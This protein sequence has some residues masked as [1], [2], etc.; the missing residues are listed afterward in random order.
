MKVCKVV[1]NFLMFQYTR[2]YQQVEL[3]WTLPPHI[4]AVADA[5]YQALCNYHDDQCCII[6]GESGAGKTE[7]AKL[8]VH[9]VINL[10]RC[11]NDLQQ[12]ILQ[13]KY[14]NCNN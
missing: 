5:A 12:Q 13:V 14:Q 10:C 11:N 8:I 1:N 7:S 3:R 9:H 2:K 6:S 4:Y